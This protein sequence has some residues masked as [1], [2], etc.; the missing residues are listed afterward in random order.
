MLQLGLALKRK[1]ANQVAG[2]SF[3][4]ENIMPEQLLKAL[5]FSLTGDQ[6]KGN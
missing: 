4:S 1:R 3:R 6:K 5:K 2:I